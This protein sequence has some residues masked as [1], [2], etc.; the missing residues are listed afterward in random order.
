MWERGAGTEI[1]PMSTI[2]VPRDAQPFDF[3][4]TTKDLTQILTNV[5]ITGIFLDD[6]NDGD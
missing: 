6:I 5:A 4:S 2:Y 3:I 1:L